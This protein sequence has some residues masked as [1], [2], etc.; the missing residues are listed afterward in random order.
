ML[1]CGIAA[2]PG[3]FGSAAIVEAKASFGLTSWNS[4]VVLIKSRGSTMRAITLAFALAVISGAVHGQEAQRIEITDYGIYSSERTNDTKAAPGTATGLV[5]NRTS[6][7]L[8][9]T[10]TTVPARIGS[11][12]GF[13]YRVIGQANGAIVNLKRIILVPQPGMRNPATGN[14]TV[15]DEYAYQKAIGGTGFASYALDDEWEVVPGTW[16][17]EIWDGNGKLASKSFDLVKP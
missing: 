3:I 2:R 15:R 5:T 10:T 8:I 9:K 1:R 12:F 16:T 7:T 13:R 4:A 14:T 6:T 17:I 11:Q